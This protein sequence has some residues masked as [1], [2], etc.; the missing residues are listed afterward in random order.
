MPAPL[1]P[2]CSFFDRSAVPVNL[3]TV[4]DWRAYALLA[5]RK[6]SWLAGAKHYAERRGGALIL[7]ADDSLQVLTK[8][9]D[10]KVRSRT[11]RP[12]KWR[13]QP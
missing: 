13:W 12:G 10:G 2:V 9:A 11:Y 6:P 3:L 5:A 4:A 1:T 7:R 8:G